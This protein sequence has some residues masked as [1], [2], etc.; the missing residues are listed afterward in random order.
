M[1]DKETTKLVC[2]RACEGFGYFCA[3]P[4]T[5]WKPGVAFCFSSKKEARVLKPDSSG[6]PEELLGRPFNGR[7]PTP[8]IWEQRASACFAGLGFSRR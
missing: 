3:P 4:S 1:E 8:T 5:S 2:A 6:L 7:M